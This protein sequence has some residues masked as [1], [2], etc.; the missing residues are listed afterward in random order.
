MTQI[1]PARPIMS[2][3]RPRLLAAMLAVTSI[4][5]IGLNAPASAQRG[6][7]PYT[8]AETG[9]GFARL[10]DA[11]TAIGAGRGTIIIAPGTHRDCAVQSEGEIVYRAAVPGQVIFDGGICEGKATLVLRGRGA[12]VDGLIFQ[13]M[14]VPDGN[15]SGI[16]LEKGNL[17]VTQ[18]WFRNS[19]Q[20]ILAG[21]DTA[22]TITVD[23]ST[24][25]R[26]GRCDRGLAC[27]HSLYIGNFASLEVTRSRF[28]AG[29][30]G[31]Y[32]KS[33]TPRVKIADCS[34]DDTAGKT[35]NYMIDL[36]AG[37]V[38]SI[39][40][41]VFVQGKDKEN[42]SAFIAVAAETRDNSSAGLRVE[43]ND[44]RIGPGVDRESWFVANWSRDPIAIIANKIGP[45]IGKYHER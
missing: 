45:N 15:G 28:E 16:R 42:Y 4:A 21:E 25:T 31:H 34:F 22:A 33:R 10:V 44:A 23:K 27:A 37:S 36:P 26:L 41:N 8:V 12:R 32:V 17:A 39:A 43:G 5:A 3:I 24:F 13:N 7:A 35:T 14:N 29:N 11:V 19:E 6:D 18:S 40:N 1:S 2:T 38:G 9:Q 30:G 20:G